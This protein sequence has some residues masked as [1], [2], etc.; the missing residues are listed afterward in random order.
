MSA[1]GQREGILP[2][3]KLGP[4]KGHALVPQP[5]SAEAIDVHVGL[6]MRLRR[7][8]LGLSQEQLAKI[9]GVTFQQ[10]QKYEKGLNR[11]GAS[12]LFHLG[13]ALGVPIQFFFDDFF[14]EKNNQCRADGV[15]DATPDTATLEFLC[16]REGFE[17]NKAFLSI[18][19]PR[20]RRTLI[21]HIRALAD[22][23]VNP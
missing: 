15:P 1:G 19:D 3:A 2:M 20:V 8:Q 16:S 5:R 13:A 9:L 10:V 11:I 7:L 18:T 23:P 17:L 22:E 21:S 12:R 6:R 14:D 4:D